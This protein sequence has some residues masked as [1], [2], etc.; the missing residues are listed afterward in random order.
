[1]GHLTVIGTAKDNKNTPTMA[2]QL[3]GF[4]QNWVATAADLPMN[5]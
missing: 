4:S 3:G 2:T 1:M 5:S